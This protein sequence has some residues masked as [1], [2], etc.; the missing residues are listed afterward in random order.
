MK[1]LFLGYIPI[2]ENV[3]KQLNGDDP[4]I[5]NIWCDFENVYY[6]SEVGHHHNPKTVEFSTPIK[7]ESLKKRLGEQNWK[8]AKAFSQKKYEYPIKA[9]W[10]LFYLD[11]KSKIKGIKISIIEKNKIAKIRF[12][13]LTFDSKTDKSLISE[14]IE[15]NAFQDFYKKNVNKFLNTFT[16]EIMN[17]IVIVS[18][19]FGY[20]FIPFSISQPS[21]ISKLKQN[22]N[23]YYQLI[24]CEKNTKLNYLEWKREHL[25]FNKHVIIDLPLNE[26]SFEA[27][28]SEEYIKYSYRQVIEFLK[29]NLPVK[30]FYSDNKPSY[31][32]PP[33]KPCL[34]VLE[35]V[36]NQITVSPGNFIFKKTAENA[37]F[38]EIK[39]LNF[40]SKDFNYAIVESI[41]PKG[42]DLFVQK[43][44]IYIVDR[45]LKP[46][47][48]YHL[49]NKYIDDLF[50]IEKVSYSKFDIY[51]ECKVKCNNQLFFLLIN[52]KTLNLEY[53]TH[54]F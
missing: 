21:V 14:E 24:L 37:K 50:T 17:E 25:K 32:K 35:K 1:E 42:E 51:L 41:Y 2:Q 11:E 9:C 29:N 27:Q 36:F 31:V 26:T 47:E 49:P 33:K 18:D 8:E 43:K 20:N 5:F 48:L 22:F 6:S 19:Y 45:S 40:N 13:S 28:T 54:H 39:D 52:R 46:K 23:A 30:Q 4:Y 38:M 3:T 53:R 16:T 15:L 12:D 34:V 7:G 44:A 10:E